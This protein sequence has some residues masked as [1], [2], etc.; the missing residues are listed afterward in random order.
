MFTAGAVVALALVVGISVSTWQA[1]RATRAE[2]DQSA[3]VWSESLEPRARLAETWWLGLRLAEGVD[4]LAARLASGASASQAQAV[5]RAAMEL[6]E[7]GLLQRLGAR[8]S[9]SERGLPLADA[10]AKRLLRIDDE[11]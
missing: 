6:V 11:A 7:Q 9:L 1:V 3:L 2:R 10:V 8:V 4:P 5:E